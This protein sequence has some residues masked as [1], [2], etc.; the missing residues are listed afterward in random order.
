MNTEFR[1]KWLLNTLRKNQEQGF[2]WIALIFVLF[3]LGLLVAIVWP[4]FIFQSDKDKQAEAK[5]Y[6]SAINKS[7]AAYY[8]E[9]GK[10]VTESTPEGWANLGV[11]IKTQT[12]NYKYVISSNG[13]DG[14]NAFAIPL[15]KNLKGYSF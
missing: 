10:F 14:V 2:N 4:I 13:K 3:I 9:N 8:T 1:I 6:V 12:T 11:G 5:K 7:Q 15:N